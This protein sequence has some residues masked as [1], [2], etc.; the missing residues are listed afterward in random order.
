MVAIR[1]DTYEQ[2]VVYVKIIKQDMV[3]MQLNSSM[4]QS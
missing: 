4:K 2:V 1:E 3:N